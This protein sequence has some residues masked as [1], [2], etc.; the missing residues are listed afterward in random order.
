MSESYKPT[1]YGSTSRPELDIPPLREWNDT[2]TN[3]RFTLDMDLEGAIER[4]V[5]DR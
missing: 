4:L 3:G 1:S 5:D 2:K